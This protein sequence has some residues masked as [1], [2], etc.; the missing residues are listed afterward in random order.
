[1]IK[2]K[3]IPITRPKPRQVSHAP[4][5]ELKENRLGVGSL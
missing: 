3:S 5:G 1:M 2:P 4:S